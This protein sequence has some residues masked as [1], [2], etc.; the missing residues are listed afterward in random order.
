MLCQFIN[1]QDGHSLDNATYLKFNFE[2]GRNVAFIYACYWALCIVLCIG[3][4]QPNARIHNFSE[5]VDTFLVTSPMRFNTAVFEVLEV[6]VI[7]RFWL[8]YYKRIIFQIH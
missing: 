1:E 3:A 4:A 8:L 6:W 2:L 7:E 5:K